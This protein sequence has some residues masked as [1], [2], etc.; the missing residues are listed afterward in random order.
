MGIDIYSLFMLG[1]VGTGHC[2]G[3]CG[4]LII[5]FPGQSK[6][7]SA[8][9]CYHCGRLTTYC[10]VGFLMGLIG[11]SLTLMASAVN[12]DP[13]RW[14]AW[15]QIGLSVVAAFLLLYLGMARMGLCQEPAWMSL[16]APEKFPGFGKT[17]NAALSKQSRTPYFILGLM[18]GLLPCG[19]SFGAFARALAVESPS[20][21]AALLLAFGLGTLPGLLALG[22]GAHQFAMRYRKQSDL[23]SGMLMIAMGIKLLLDT[24]FN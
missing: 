20:Y 23:L 14:V 24:L 1:L 10:A 4:P 18:F 19:L 7:I 6:Q 22:V 3:M 21:G 5:A 15:T 11:K 12:A 9:L 13:L 17:L 16:A 2:L 8:H